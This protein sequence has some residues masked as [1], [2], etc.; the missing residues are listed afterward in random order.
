MFDRRLPL[1]AHVEPEGQIPVT[2][3]TDGTTPDVANM[4]VAQAM[5]AVDEAQIALDNVR[6]ALAD[7]IAEAR[8]VLDRV[9]GAMRTK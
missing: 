7:A 2:G 3:T 6:A 4:T 9:E 1:G 5:H 8:A